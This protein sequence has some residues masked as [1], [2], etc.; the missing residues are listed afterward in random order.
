MGQ[1]KEKQTN[2]SKKTK[3]HIV[4]NL[5]KYLEPSQNLVN[6]RCGICFHPSQTGYHLINLLVIIINELTVQNPL[7]ANYV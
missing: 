5:I 3:V 2:K 1:E 6:I 4:R 7:S